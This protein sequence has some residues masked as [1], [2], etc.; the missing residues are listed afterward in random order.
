MSISTEDNAKII[1]LEQLLAEKDKI[2]VGQNAQLKLIMETLQ[3]MNS[4]VK[5][6]DELN[7]FF[8]PDK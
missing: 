4:L 5:L 2:I 8:K 6:V 3:S 7:L 1:E